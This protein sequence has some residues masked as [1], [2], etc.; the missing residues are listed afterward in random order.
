M[1]EIAK[2]VY[3]KYRIN[4]NNN[5]NIED[6]HY[7]SEIKNL[8]EESMIKSMTNV[9]P[10]R[11]RKLLEWIAIIINSNNVNITITLNNWNCE[12]VKSYS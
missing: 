4:S 12:L 11:K 3:N 10:K 5:A 2:Y 8:C 7:D 1:V 9:R 6:E